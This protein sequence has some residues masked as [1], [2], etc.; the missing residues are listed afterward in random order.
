VATFETMNVEL[1]FEA[2]IDFTPL[3][4]SGNHLPEIGLPSKRDHN[5]GKVL[6][7]RIQYYYAKVSSISRLTR[8]LKH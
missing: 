5:I 2:V 7:Y 8:W 6:K 4:A 1:D 3:G